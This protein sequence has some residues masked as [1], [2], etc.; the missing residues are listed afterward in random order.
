MS[1]IVYTEADLVALKK[2]LLS[3]NSEVTIGDQRVRFKSTAEIIKTI[4]IVQ[5]YL[6]GIPTVSS[7]VIPATFSK[8]RK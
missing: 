7:N 5:D 2:A 3:P 1:Q 8:G 4:Q 6:R